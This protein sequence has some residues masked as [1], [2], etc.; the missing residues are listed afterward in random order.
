[1]AFSDLPVPNNVFG[2]GEEKLDKED[3]NP[4]VKEQ[5]EMKFP[6]NFNMDLY[7]EYLDLINHGTLKQNK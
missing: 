5:V 6:S 2:E 4:V 1:M 3:E 7:K